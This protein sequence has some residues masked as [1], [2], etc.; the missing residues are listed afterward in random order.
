[1]IYLSKGGAGADSDQTWIRP[2]I[3]I[4]WQPKGK[5]EEKFIDN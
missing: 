2:C 1:M 3:G 4:F 5:P